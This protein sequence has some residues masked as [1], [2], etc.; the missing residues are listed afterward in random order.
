MVKVNGNK[1]EFGSY[2]ATGIAEGFEEADSEEHAIAAWQYLV[3]T[4]LAWSLQGA[5]GRAATS[6]IDGGIIVAREDY[7]AENGIYT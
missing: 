4:G 7:D 6:L 3:N 1:Y 2:M 5:F